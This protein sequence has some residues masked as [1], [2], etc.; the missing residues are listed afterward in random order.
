MSSLTPTLPNELW[1]KTLSHLSSSH[2]DL[3]SCTLINRQIFPLAASLLYRVI[4][5]DIL[6]AKN[7]KSLNR[8][9]ISN[10]T[11]ADY[12]RTIRLELGHQQ[13]ESKSLY[14]GS[15]S[16]WEEFARLLPRMTAL[17]ELRLG[18]GGRNENPILRLVLR[19]ASICSNPDFIVRIADLTSY[20]TLQILWL[21]RDTMARRLTHLHVC[22]ISRRM[23]PLIEA[24]FRGATQLEYAHLDIYDVDDSLLSPRTLPKSIK[25]L[26]IDGNKYP[27]WLP[28]EIKELR[29]AMYFCYQIPMPTWELICKTSTLEYIDICLLREREESWE[30][31]GTVAKPHLPAVLSNRI[32]TNLRILKLLALWPGCPMARS[33]LPEV[34]RRPRY[35]PFGFLD[36]VFQNN[37]G[38]QDVTVD[39]LSASQLQSLLSTCHGLTA[40]RW[41][42]SFTSWIDDDNV[43]TEPALLQALQDHPQLHL[44]TLLYPCS[45]PLLFSFRTITILQFCPQLKQWRCLIPTPALWKAPRPNRDSY[46]YDSIFGDV[47]E[48]IWMTECCNNEDGAIVEEWNQLFYRCC[49][50]RKSVNPLMTGFPSY[51]EII[52]GV[53]R[54]VPNFLVDVGEARQLLGEGVHARY[55]GYPRGRGGVLKPLTRYPIDE[56]AL[57]SFYAG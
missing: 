16:P 3:F 33:S 37:P 2:S 57:Y 1:L 12:I 22:E 28:P 11:L 30:S 52:S 17:R 43:V 53:Q 32:C 45:A 47:A 25:L 14:L 54:F 41:F 15:W 36:R 46:V 50:E 7:V 18:E 27:T 49:V 51:D 10:Y 40:I 55:S 39:S 31:W 24:I 8:A 29:L 42:F 38:L 44:N 19:S 34:R 48:H 21:G 13:R 9:L 35:F 6:P 5:L 20:E 26:S 56:D 23:V 4:P